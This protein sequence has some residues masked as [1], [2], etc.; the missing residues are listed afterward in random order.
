MSEV[1]FL[2]ISDT[3]LHPST[4]YTNEHTTL[5]PL[6]CYRAMI[7]AIQKLPFELDFILHTGDVT[8]DPEPNYYPAIAELLGEL[9]YPTHYVLGNHDDAKAFQQ[10]MLGHHPNKVNDKYFYTFEHNGVQFICLDS[11]DPTNPPAG[12]VSAEQLMWLDDL[13]RANDERPLVVAVHHNILPLGI[14]WLDKYMRVQNSKEV[15]N[16]LQKATHRLQVVLHGHIHS[17][18]QVMRDGVFYCSAGSA[19][20]QLSA[21]PH[22]PNEIKDSI[23]HPSFNI[24]SVTNQQTFIQRHAFALPSV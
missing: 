21:F 9:P 10:I 16:I 17:N 3:H 15:H 24:V 12:I 7:E 14:S 18:L 5:S 19:W 6:V 11:V 13:C 20:F 4:S 2:H 1:T 23:A 22:T 8:F